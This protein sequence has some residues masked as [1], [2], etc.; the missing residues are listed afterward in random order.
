MVIP[1]FTAVGR[2]LLQ[3][4]RKGFLLLAP[5]KLEVFHS[6]VKILVDL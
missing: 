4:S 3:R 6:L 5:S 2:V 1:F